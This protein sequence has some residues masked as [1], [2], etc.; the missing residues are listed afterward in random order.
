MANIAQQL[1]DSL[2]LCLDQLRLEIDDIDDR[3]L[4][5]VEQRL[6][7]SR[8]IAVLKD[9]QES[10]FLKLRPRREKAVIARLAARA[11][12]APAELIDQLWRA[13]MSYGLH[14]Q[15][16]TE[17]VLCARR[18]PAGVQEQV[19]NRFGLAPPIRWAGAPAEAIAAARAREAVAVI[20]NGLPFRLEEDDELVMFESLYDAQ[21]RPLARA[22]GRVAPAD[23]AAEMR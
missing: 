1:Q 23:I 4:A 16:E 5:L 17:L 18:D 6:A 12:R 19:R 21:G 13:L 20:E 8:A 14:A 10:R 11:D 2:P 3:L 9:R 22:I 15:V 7:T